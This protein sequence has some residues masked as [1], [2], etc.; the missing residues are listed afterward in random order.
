MGVLLKTPVTDL[1]EM[2][3][4][5]DDAEDMFDA[6]AD[7]GLDTVTSPLD[8]VYHALVPI[9]AVGKVAGLRGVLPE[10]VGLTLVGRVAPDFGFLTMSI[11]QSLNESEE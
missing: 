2:E 7:L 8:L 6:A 1:G 10:D 4:A 9:P 5:L 11:F 3:D